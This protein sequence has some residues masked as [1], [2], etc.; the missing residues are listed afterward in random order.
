MASKSFVMYDEWTPLFLSL[1]AEKAGELIQAVFRYRDSGDTEPQDRTVNAMFQMIKARM[2]DDAAR[3]E[4]R[5][6]KN[7]AIA[8]E[9]ERNRTNVHEREPNVTDSDSDSDSN[10]DIKE[11]EIKER[12]RRVIFVRPTVEDV[13]AYCLERKNN[14]DAQT[15]VDFYSAKGWKVGSAPMKDWKACVRTW[16]KREKPKADKWKPA[17]ERQYDFDELEKRLL[18]R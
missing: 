6:A 5:C 18:A 11:K 10:K 7:K 14:V 16:E 8:I 2:D 17:N 15:F 3:Y 9:R 4:T 12:E 13:R 1:P